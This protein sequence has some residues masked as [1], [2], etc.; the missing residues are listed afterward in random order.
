MA[1]YLKVQISSKKSYKKNKQYKKSYRKKQSVQKI[2]SKKQPVA[3]NLSSSKN[4]LQSSKRSYDYKSIVS[5]FVR[6]RD[7]FLA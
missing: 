5:A 1:I 7:F 3:K 6:S 4:I 2:L